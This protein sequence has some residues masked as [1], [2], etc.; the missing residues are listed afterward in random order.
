MRDLDTQEREIVRELI[1]N[2]RV[3]DNQI[4]RTTQIPVMSVN[5]KRKALEKS[6]LL[7]YFTSLDTGEHGT[8]K[9]KAKQMYLIK[10]K[11]GITRKDFLNKVVPGKRLH[12]FSA[13]Y[14]SFS[15]LGEKDG[16]LSYMCILDAQTESHLT[17]K[18]NGTLI[19]FLKQA[20]GDEC[21]EEI[22]TMRITNTIRINHNYVPM[23]NMQ[24]GILTPDWPDGCIFVD[25][26][27]GQDQAEPSRESSI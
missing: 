16:H 19:P 3:S 15:C 9:Y 20:L 23:M 14:I 25:E 4:S 8:G 26:E 24:D 17:D 22:T 27:I 6:G 12:A 18:F 2:P 10:F 1:R 7:R 13:C 5:R 21:I 11:I